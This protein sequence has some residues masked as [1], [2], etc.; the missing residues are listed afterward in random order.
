MKP[1]DKEGPLEKDVISAT[2]ESH[3]L[4][5]GIGAVGGT[6]AGAAL[7]SALGPL[8]AL[9]GAAIGSVA[10]AI[11]GRGI[12]EGID[13]D[14]EIAYWQRRYREE[15]YYQ[16]EYAFDDYGPAYGLGWRLYA[17]DSTFE[18]VEP[19]MSESWEKERGSSRLPWHH[20]RDAARASWERVHANRQID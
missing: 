6:L 14:A 3:P 11:A 15:P 19:R 10:G 5:T 2:A 17:P 1:T 13:P 12:A 18:S 9:T 20:A 16:S 4:G 7:G 8:G